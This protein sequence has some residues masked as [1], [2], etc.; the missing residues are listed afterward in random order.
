MCNLLYWG[1]GP[2][3]RAVVQIVHIHCFG[4]ALTEK[5]IKIAT[6]FLIK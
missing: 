3:V 5:K 6:R 2:R 1:E 4:L